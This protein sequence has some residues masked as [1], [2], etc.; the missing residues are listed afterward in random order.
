MR[1]FIELLGDWL[2]AYR[3]AVRRY[4]ALPVH[5]V[6]ASAFVA[7]VAALAAAVPYLLREATNLLSTQDA[8]TR[9]Q[10]AIL[11]AGAYGL[12]WT[13]AQ[14]CEWLKHMLSAAVLARCD[15]AFHEIIY[16]T[17][18]RVDY[19]RLAE[20]DPGQLV[21]VVARSREAF[22]A[23]TYAL[24]WVIAPTLFQLVLS[25][26][27]L[28]QATSGVFALVF[29]VSMLALFVVTFFIA[30]RSKNAHEQIF[31]A[32]DLLTSHLVEKLG[33][34]L[35]VKV[36]NAY[37]REG[38]AA[39]DM[40]RR[41]VGRVSRGN[42]RL[43]LLLAAQ[44]ACTGLLLTAFT[45]AAARG[46]TTSALR[47]GDFV[48]IVGYVV[49]LTMPFAT[50]AASLS[51]L[52]R[53]HLALREG[54][55]LLEWPCERPVASERLLPSAEYV[56]R[57][58]RV[59]VRHAG[60]TVLHDVDLV[61]APGDRIALSGPSGAGK[62]SL[63]NLLLGLARPAAGTVCLYGTDVS[64]LSVGDIARH[65]AVA[66]QTPMILSGSLRDNLTYGCERAPSDDCLR[67]WV[68]L[69]E[70]GDLAGA[71]AGDVLNRPLGVQGRALSGGERQRI[72]LGRAMLRRPAVV[73]LDEP[74]SSLDAG[75]ES[76]IFER[77][78]AC[79]PTVIV[80]THRPALLA[81]VDRVYRVEAGTVREV[82]REA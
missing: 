33:F 19:A 77:I 37:E 78:M 54:F 23:L 52:R 76:R 6:G 45:V 24:C 8:A 40:L 3:L 41:Y 4:P 38:S 53:N 43:S 22:S 48:M 64:T 13:A 81:L 57:L 27:V 75:R 31:G 47:V 50:L 35:D 17:L 59:A 68:D 44:A 2:R 28:W 21:A 61:V 74:T 20:A 67:E 5:F 60:K 26:T 46:V 42:A 73:I 34:L 80:I 29:I 11:L 7:L 63:A 79:V 69:L 70:L 82:D 55:G 18:L 36:N 1:F 10:D 51:D 72:A 16:T 65:I 9:A 71:G 49:A 32:A 39:R 62:S 15:A 56:Y 30:S 66:P 58:D 12:A 25:A 14:A